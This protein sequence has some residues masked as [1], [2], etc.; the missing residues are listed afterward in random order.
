MNCLNIA[1]LSQVLYNRIH[2][3]DKTPDK[4]VILRQS[5]QSEHMPT[6]TDQNYL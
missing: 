1:I 2:L 4:V 6:K 3:F 5:A